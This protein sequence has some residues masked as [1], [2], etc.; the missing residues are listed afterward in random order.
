ML[1]YQLLVIVLECFDGG[2]NMPYAFTYDV[3]AND[4]IYAKIR[5]LLPAE[6]PSGMINHVVLRHGDGLRY[7]DVWEDEAAWQ[8]F[9]ET[10]G[11]PAVDQ[12]LSS[13]GL[14]HDHSLVRLE[15]IEVIDVWQGTAPFRTP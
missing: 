9:M 4:E 7:L 12:V 3:P 6:P 11:E 10:V 1:L 14:P 13:Y 8:R 5:A 2:A 15:E